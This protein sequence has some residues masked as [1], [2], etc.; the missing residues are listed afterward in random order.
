MNDRVLVNSSKRISCLYGKY[1]SSNLLLKGK[2]H[3]G[4]DIS[5]SSNEEEN[6]VYANCLGVVYEV[7][8]GLLRDINAKG[9]ETWGNFVLVK[10][11]NGMFSRY[12]HLVKGSIRVRV[13][14]QV[15]ENTFL[16]VMGESGITFGRHLHFEVAS[17]YSSSTRINPTPYLT[18]AIYEEVKYNDNDFE[19]GDRVL[20]LSGYA[21]S[22][23]YGGGNHTAEYTGNVN[24][25][26]DIKYITDIVSLDRP[27]PYH[28]SND[29]ENKKPRGWVSKE[30]IRKI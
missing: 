22:D 24:D 9:K 8:D 14:E 15:N 16:G 21:T 18:K 11:P 28:L 25:A 10:H 1:S 29:R 2:M 27:R 20:V 4:V 23:S 3:H 17:G 6:K 19:V 30:Q 13:G 7:Q 5:Y 12:A 26:G